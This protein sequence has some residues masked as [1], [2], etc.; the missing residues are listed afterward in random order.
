MAL[1]ASRRRTPTI[2]T[3]PVAIWDLLDTLAPDALWI[4][5][6]Q[7]SEQAYTIWYLDLDYSY[8]EWLATLSLDGRWT[9]SPRSGPCY[10]NVTTPV[11]D[12]KGVSWRKIR[13]HRREKPTT[14]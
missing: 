2:T 5:S 4:A 11:Q 13:A 14:T 12:D 9:L 8:N 10:D 3:L 1:K 6:E 7:H